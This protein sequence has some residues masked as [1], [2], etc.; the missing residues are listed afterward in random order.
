MGT[1]SSLEGFVS[2][3]GGM[4]ECGDAVG[5]MRENELTIPPSLPN[6][7]T[8]TVI[9]FILKIGTK[10]SDGQC[11]TTHRQGREFDSGPRALQVRVC[12]CG[13]AMNQGAP[14]PFAKPSARE[15]N[16]RAS[17]RMNGWIAGNRRAER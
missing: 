12:V 8:L 13:L 4:Q 15:G 9:F 5:K 10:V 14:G 6:Y 17:E 2:Q 7:L 1:L 11:I 16:E 3:C